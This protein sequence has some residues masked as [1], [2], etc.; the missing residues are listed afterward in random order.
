MESTD[1]KTSDTAS[2]LDRVPMTKKHKLPAKDQIQAG[3]DLP[4][5]ENAKAVFNGEY[6]IVK[7]LG[8]GAASKVYLCRSVIDQKR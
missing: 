4:P 7:K 6:E 1:G 2:S 5:L 8:E 3:Y